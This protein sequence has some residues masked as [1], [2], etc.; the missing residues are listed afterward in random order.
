MK[1][2]ILSFVLLTALLLTLFCA[3]GNKTKVL[4]SQEALNSALE[5][6]GVGESD[7]GDVHTQI[8]T[9]DTPGFSFHI[10]IG[11]KEYG[12]FVNAVTG[13]VSPIDDIGH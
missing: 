10:T 1:T 9:G 13:E 3:C 8:S 12:V 7:I 5:A 11:E 4:S 2:R 6:L